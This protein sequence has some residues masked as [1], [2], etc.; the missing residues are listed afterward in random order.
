MWNQ[1]AGT[2]M[3]G[4]V[5]WINA[6]SWS[7]IASPLIAFTSIMSHRLTRAS[8]GKHFS[9]RLSREKIAIKHAE[10]VTLYYVNV[11]HSRSAND[12][13][14]VSLIKEHYSGRSLLHKRRNQIQ[15]C[16]CESHILLERY[17]NACVAPGLDTCNREAQQQHEI[18]HKVLSHKLWLRQCVRWGYLVIICV[19]LG[20]KVTQSCVQQLWL[21]L[22]VLLHEN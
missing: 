17:I 2:D 1:T 5:V 21:M 22:L 3:A 8:V 10:H 7:M 9:Q 13:T 14:T 15:R 6:D 12:M 18:H 19:E 16:N 11:R 20:A 4:G